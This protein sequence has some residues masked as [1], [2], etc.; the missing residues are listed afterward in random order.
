MSEIGT[1]STT[2]TQPLDGIS[3]RGRDEGGNGHIDSVEVGVDNSRSL[4]LEEEV[5]KS[6]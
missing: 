6:I 2:S 4:L 1:K 5:R 3:E